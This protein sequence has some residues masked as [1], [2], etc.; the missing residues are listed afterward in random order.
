MSA[1][2]QIEPTISYGA[3]AQTIALLGGIITW[4]MH[5]NKDISLIKADISNLQSSHQNFSEAFKQLGQILTQ[6]AVQDVRLL[7]TEKRLDEL[8]HGKGFVRDE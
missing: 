7:N 3:I 2:I 8:A 6:V 4:G 5:L 1:L